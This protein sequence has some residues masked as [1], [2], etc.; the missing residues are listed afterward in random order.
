VTCTL[1]KE[2]LGRRGIPFRSLVPLADEASREEWR[3]YGS[4]PV[5]A[6]VV[7]GRATGVLHVSQFYS[8]LGVAPDYELDER[9]MVWDLISL[10]KMWHRLVEALDWELALRP[11]PARNR[12]IRDIVVNV[13]EFIPPALAARGTGTYILALEPPELAQTFRTR[14]ALLEY[15]DRHIADS[16]AFAL[17][18]YSGEESEPAPM[19]SVTERLETG[20]RERSDMPYVAL[21]GWLANHTAGHLRQCDAFLAGLGIEHAPMG[22]D[23]FEYLALA[24]DPFGEGGDAFGPAALQELFTT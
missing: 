12:T 4:P 21:L 11:T 2:F 6:L 10:E 15:V 18:H 23:A 19:I 7:N 8:L 9:R 22:L 24:D 17:E 20:V 3:S 13:F 14:D 16:E 5:P 1:A